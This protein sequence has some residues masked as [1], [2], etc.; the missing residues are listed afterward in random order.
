MIRSTPLAT[1]A[2]ALLVSACGGVRAPD[3]DD[4]RSYKPILSWNGQLNPRDGQI[5]LEVSSIHDVSNGTF[6][7]HAFFQTMVR[8]FSPAG[9]RRLRLDS[10]AESSQVADLDEDGWQ[11][12]VLLAGSA[13]RVVSFRD[14]A[15]TFREI[16][17]DLHSG[18]YLAKTV[19]LGDHDGDGRME[20]I[21]P[22][23]ESELEQRPRPAI[24]RWKSSS[25]FRQAVTP[26]ANVVTLPAEFAGTTQP[27]RFV[28]NGGTWT[29]AAQGLNLDTTSGRFVAITEWVAGED[30]ANFLSAY[31]SVGFWVE[32][33]GKTMCDRGL[34][35]VDGETLGPIWERASRY[36]YV[37]GT[38]LKVMVVFN[39]LRLK[40]AADDLTAALRTRLISAK[41]VIAGLPK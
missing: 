31:G 21:L 24:R 18:V 35:F 41:K 32:K 12:I 1:L 2:A 34:S 27:L 28:G 3:Y 8:V 17:D 15:L 20:F 37:T 16:E 26:G 4:P 39:D 22:V 7:S 5:H 19:Q 9:E 25:G 6:D 38:T 10:A 13:A 30:L 14:G 40:C 29:Q 23:V 36:Y 11:E 33:D